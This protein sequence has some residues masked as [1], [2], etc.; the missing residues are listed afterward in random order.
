VGRARRARAEVAA[1][2]A[3][4]NR[5][6]PGEPSPASG[7]VRLR[8]RQSRLPAIFLAGRDLVAIRRRDGTGFA[9]YVNADGKRF[10]PRTAR[11]PR[12]VPPRGPRS[13]LQG[14]AYRRPWRS[15]PPPRSGP[16]GAVTGTLARPVADRSGPESAVAGRSR[17]RASVRLAVPAGPV[18][19]A[20]G[21]G[22]LPAS[23]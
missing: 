2:P 18:C 16:P 17:R 11:S 15:G 14:G 7:P 10:A 22:A 20:L 21:T 3:D 9:F 1:Q 6:A 23:Q 4:T 12:P 13:A 19:L 8:S 5:A